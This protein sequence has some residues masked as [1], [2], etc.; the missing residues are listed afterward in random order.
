M[1]S[2]G[3]VHTVVVLALTAAL[4]GVTASRASAAADVWLWACH[5]PGG[6]AAP[7]STT[8]S[9]SVTDFEGGCEQHGAGGKRLTVTN[10]TPVGTAVEY[11]LPATGDYAIHAVRILHRAQG[12][13]GPACATRSTLDSAGHACSTAGR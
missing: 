12:L 7:V 11:K 10:A 9:P 2:V 3:R 5:G 1:P 6:E 4:L 8:N 13:E